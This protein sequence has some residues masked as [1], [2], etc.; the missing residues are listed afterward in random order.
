MGSHRILSGAM[1]RSPLLWTRRVVLMKMSN[2]VCRRSRTTYIG[3]CCLRRP[4]SREQHHRPSSPL[5]LH[6]YSSPCPRWARSFSPFP[7]RCRAFSSGGQVARLV[8]AWMNVN[9]T[10][11]EPE[12]RHLRLDPVGVCFEQGRDNIVRLSIRLDAFALV[13]VTVSDRSTR[14]RARHGDGRIPLRSSGRRGA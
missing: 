7:Q 3:R 14:Q 4:T 10:E 2:A 11:P 5:R 12:S 9:Y 6:H 1:G 8:Q 13:A